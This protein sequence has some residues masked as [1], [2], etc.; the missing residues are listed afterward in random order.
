MKNINWKKLIPHLIAVAIFAIIAII[1]CKPAFDGKVLQ[2]DDTSQWRAMAQSSFK[3]KE[4]HGH[5][6]LWTNSMFC[7]MPAYQIAMDLENLFS[8]E[9]LNKIVTLG[10]PKPASFFFLA[11]ICF[12][13]LACA[14]R[15]NPYVAIATALSY[16]Y[17]TYNPIIIAVGHETKMLAIAW[18]P[19]LIGSLV[20]LFDKKYI[21][22]TFLT[23]F[24]S[25]YLIGANHL[26]ITYYTAII[27]IF[28][29]ISFA[30]YCF[31]HKQ[32]K[33]LFVVAALAILAAFVGVGNNIMTLR[34]TSEYGK[35]SIRGGSALATD[36]DKGKATKTG[37]NKDYAM[38]YSLFKTEPLA[39]MIPR[40]FGG[41]SGEIDEAK[42]KA[43][44]KLLEMQPQLAQQLQGYIQASYWGGIGATAGPPYIGAIVCFLAFIGFVILDNKYKWWI[45]GCTVFTLM[46]SWGKY[47]DGFNTWMLA[48]LPAYDKFRA[49]SMILVV[50]TF[51][52]TMMAALALQEIVNTENKEDIWKKYKKGLLV[53]AGM[54]LV[55][56]LVY[57]SSDFA[58]EADKNLLKQIADL[59]DAQQRDALQAPIKGFVNALRDDR[60]AL[61]M[62]DF[63]RTIGF[64]LIAAVMLWL[65]IKNKISGLIATIV[66]GVFAFIDVMTIDV[67]YLNSDKF[68]EVDSYTDTNFKET[69][70]ITN[71]L[72]D[73]SQFRVFNVSRGAFSAFNEDAKTSYYLNSI[74]GYHPAKLSIY[75]DLAEKQLYDFPRSMNVVNM[76][77]G[78]YII[79]ANQQG[80]QI[81]IPNPDALGNCWFVKGVTYKEKPLEIMN[82]LN[83]LNTNDSAVVDVS[84]KANV[85]YD[86]VADSTAKINLVKNEN[87]FIE[88]ASTSS[89]SKFAVFSEVYYNAGWKAYIDGKEAPIVRTNYVLRGL[90]I[91]SG[92]HKITFDFKPDS[93]YTSKNIV[94]LSSG[95]L[96]LMLIGAVI[97]SF[98][99]ERRKQKIA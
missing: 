94:Q 41:G 1:Y 84:D 54:L 51:L 93:Y 23:A 10:L 72:K 9:P 60:R 64:M 15:C 26:Q 50:P 68:I 98:F 99:H 83:T 90:S 39:M 40:A 70:V 62:G 86:E 71:I 56:V 29:S 91:P 74:G 76:L 92:T 66:I 38:S 28:M 63:M 35:L 47:F 14:L 48:H 24:T 78:K 25:A 69:P 59:Q 77:N 33:H 75:Q 80:Q 67:K 53:V 65:T 88:Y 37:L 42:S 82:A 13:F 81:A 95:L 11:C 34:T 97:A 8:T 55:S 21:W 87:D 20:L 27:I 44:E 45:L 16:A 58:G 7:G 73:K 46:L 30:V 6:P 19:A 22:G 18:M 89:S 43:S 52:L 49:P 79:Q 5:F 61:F 4:T 12:Y 2:Q 57:L 3:F 36:N 32:I 96:W 85:K 31:I 17:C